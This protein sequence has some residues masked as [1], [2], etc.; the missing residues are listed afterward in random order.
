MSTKNE[1]TTLDLSYFMRENKP[2]ESEYPAPKGFVDKDGNRINLKFR[3]LS[4]SEITEI[5]RHWR[6][7]RFA[8]DERT[9]RY[10]FTPTGKIATYENYDGDSAMRE[11]LV[12][13]LVYPNLRDKNLMA[14]FNCVNAFDMPTNVFTR[15]EYAYVVNAFDKLHGYGDVS[16]D[17]DEEDSDIDKAKN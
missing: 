11:M 4:E 16:N 1:N 3:I 2:S 6:E 5:R 13:S 9:G 7:T 10:I 14:H 12:E 8:K 15:D 17:D